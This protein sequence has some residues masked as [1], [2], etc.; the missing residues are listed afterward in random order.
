MKIAIIGEQYSA[1]LGDGVICETVKGIVN[2]NFDCETI[3]IDISGASK[4][5]EEYVQGNIIRNKK[6]KKNKLYLILR[7]F[8][9]K[10]KKLKSELERVIR[11]KIS[12][13][14]SLD[15]DV[16]LI[17]FAGGQLFM[18]YFVF[19]IYITVRYAK[20]N[21]I[22]IIFNSCGIG[23]NNSLIKRYI[24]KKALNYSNIKVISVRDNL[25]K[26]IQLYGNNNCNIVQTLDPAIHVK[27]YY[28]IDPSIKR[29]VIG[30]GVITPST[31]AKK[32]L[33]YSEEQYIK[34]NSDIIKFLNG[35]EYKWKIFTNGNEEDYEFLLLLAEKFNIKEHIVDRPK[36]PRE[37]VDLLNSFSMIISFRLHSHIIANSI[38]IPSVG[39]VWDKKVRE[40]SEII[41]NEKN[42]FDLEM[43]NLNQDVI[44]RLKDILGN[45]REINYS[46]KLIST[47][48]F[49]RCEIK[50][51]I[52]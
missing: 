22:P 39:F 45:K 23:E 25:E 13:Q 21:N 48:E 8:Y 33:S 37:L 29:D 6:I 1:N 27:K 30:V 16:K 4:F 32:G 20:K 49:L 10:I 2:E 34:L 28:N 5:Q 7:N 43:K 38:G 18:D 17:I 31:F 26:F 40:Y 36:E 11:V 24:L 52:S 15:S 12:L 3:G 50:K 14:K 46:Q 47:E 44:K 41:N 51:V 35:N 9:R 19:P 42:F